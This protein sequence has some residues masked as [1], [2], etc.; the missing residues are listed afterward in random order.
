[1]SNHQET[2]RE[3][4]PDFRWGSRL[5]VGRKNKEICFYDSFIYD[6]NQYALYD[7]VYLHN[8]DEP[9]PFIGKLVKIYEMPT[10]EKKVTVVW[11]FRPIEIDNFLKGYEPC[12]NEIFLATGEGVGVSNRIALVTRIY[13]SFNIFL[14]LL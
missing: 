7:N 12:R 5:G 10:Q 3:E 1:M 13:Y 2:K 9:E 4:K 11:Y 8:D 6:G 14:S